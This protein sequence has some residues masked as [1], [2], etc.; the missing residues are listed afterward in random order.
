MLTKSKKKI[1]LENSFTFEKPRVEKLLSDALN[2]SVK[3]ESA[4]SSGGGC[5]NDCFALETSAGKFF[6]KRN[7]AN[8]FPK[9][10]EAEMKGLH[11]LN[12]AVSVITPEVI[13]QSESGND[14]FLILEN[15]EKGKTQ[16][17]FWND[18]AKK[19]AALHK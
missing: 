7:D 18:F 14:Q 15:I 19:L 6:L 3:I 1:F 9:M 2:K 17:E 4:V 10:F 13:A 5:I 8:K 12:D 11:L 16:K